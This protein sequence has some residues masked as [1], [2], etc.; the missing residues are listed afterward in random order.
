MKLTIARALN[1]VKMLNKRIEKAQSENSF[2][3]F[4]TGSKQ[5]E[6]QVASD[7]ADS[8]ASLEGLI[9]RRAKIKNAISLANASTKIKIGA[10]EF[11]IAEA[12]ALKEG[13]SSKRTM[14]QR[15]AQNYQAIKQRVNS[16]NE[17]ADERLATLL[18]SNFGKDKKASAED[19]EAIS[20]PFNKSNQSEVVNEAEFVAHFSLKEEAIL[21]FE[22]EVDFALS[23][24][25]ALTQIEIPE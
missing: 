18:Q 8:F 6:P 19:F 14:L 3:Q 17:D 24:A 9:T 4:K 23:E 11:T 25:N 12:I 15:A 10:D 22:S 2:L 1:E 20:G 7:F 16:L 5:A 21:L 13:V